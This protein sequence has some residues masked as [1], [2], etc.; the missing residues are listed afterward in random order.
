MY[1]KSLA[2][3][4]VTFCYFLIANSQ[5]R[6][7]FKMMLDGVER[8]FIVVRPSGLAPLGGFPVVFMFHGTS[9]TGEQFYNTSGWKEKG[10]KEKFISVFPTSLKYCILNFPTNNPAILTR[11]NTGD[12]QS[13]KCPNFQQ[14]FKDDVKFVRQIVDTIRNKYI[15]DNKKIYAVGFS[16]GGS[17]VHKLAVAATDLF[18]AVASVASVLQSLDSTRASKNIRL[19]NMVGSIDERFTSVFSVNE[20]P[21]GSDSILL[22]MNAYIKRTQACLGLSNVFTK[23]STLGTLTYRYSTPSS[24]EVPSSFVF[25]LI[26]GMEHVYPIGSNFPINATDLF[27]DFFNLSIPSKSEDQL[28]DNLDIKIYPNPSNDFVNVE[29]NGIDNAKID[30]IDVFNSLRNCIYTYI[31]LEQNTLLLDKNDIG[32]GLFV[33]TVSISGKKIVRKILL[34]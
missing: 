6:T 34:Q 1:A 25:T 9:G 28:L 16:N 14:T 7:D 29:I 33:L 8:E 27:W 20:L 19:W 4:L 18:S 17:M 5:T 31:D 12:L 23:S 15:I 10:Q 11:W 24:A 21:L 32:K 13:D 26:K 2:T 22:Y 3:V 30:Q